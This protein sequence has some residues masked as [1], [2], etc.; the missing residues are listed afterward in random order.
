MKRL[1]KEYAFLLPFLAVAM[2]AVGSLGVRSALAD[3]VAT[4][5]TAWG[6]VTGTL[7][8]QTDLQT[9][10]NGKLSSSAASTTQ[11]SLFQKLYVGGT[12]T[13]TI[14]SFGNVTIPLGALL[15]VSGSSALATTTITTQ[16]NDGFKVSGVAASH[17]G[18]FQNTGTGASHLSFCNSTTG[19]GITQGVDF[20]MRSTANGNNALIRNRVATGGIDFLVNTNTN[21]LSISSAG[22]TGIGTSTPTYDLT[23][24]SGKSAV[25]QEVALAT[26]TSMTLTPDNGSQQLIRMGSAAMTITAGAFVAGAKVNF[27][28]CNPNGTAGTITWSGFHYFGGSAPTQTTTANQCDDYL[29]QATQ[30]TSTTATSPLVF[31][32]QAGAGLQ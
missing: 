24:S 16:D 11:L 32:A 21:A 18:L 25:V 29:A 4:G 3:R 23:L 17:L 28:V 31:L 14:D 20:G 5:G 6:T 8:N 7:S 2:I 15:T 9:A 27:I 30:A 13:T 26:S 19:C 10:L 1:L 22:K 12:A